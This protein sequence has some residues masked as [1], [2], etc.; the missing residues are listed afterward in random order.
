MKFYLLS[1][2]GVPMNQVLFPT[3]IKTFEVNGNVF[4]DRIED[5]D[6]VMMDLHSRQFDY[7]QSD[8][9]WIL[10]SNVSVV[11][12]DEWDRGNMSLDTYPHPLTKQQAEIFLRMEEDEIKN[13]N[14][15]RLLNMTEN[16]SYR[17][18]PYEK[19]ISYEE[20]VLTADE[21]FNREYDV[22]FIANQS[23]SRD[24][25]A[26]ALRGDGRLNCFISIGA[27]KR[28]FEE[29]LRIHKLG[30]LFI[31]SGAGGYTDERKQCLF[32]IAGLIQ[33][34]TD[35][36]LLHPFTHLEN[37]IKIN[38]P[39]TKQNLDAIFEVVNNKEKL[40]EIYHNGY[41]YMKKFYSQEY[42]SRNILQTII[43]NL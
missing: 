38:N 42:I 21:L 43:N 33:E 14:F 37:C 6:V 32:S 31:S 41:N 23:P 3:M 28:P 4:V 18:F 7:K 8:I 25:I 39:P 15:C 2:E 22:V 12:F 9:D 34:N 10:G 26:E 30:K 11:T 27:E 24:R 36:L 35:Q 29:F 19:P 17:V 16:Y 40:Y 20:P 5:C 1:P 13:V